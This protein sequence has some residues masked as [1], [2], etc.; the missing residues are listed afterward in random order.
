MVPQIPKR[1]PRGFT[2]VELLAAVAIVAILA[3]I[4][5]PT[6]GAY[7][8]RG[9][10][11]AAQSYLLTLAQAQAQYFADAHTYATTTAAL[12]LPPPG[13]VAAN[14]TIQIDASDGPPPSFTI[15]A[16]PIAG[17]RQ[18]SDSVLTIDNSGARTPSNLW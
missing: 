4:A 9:H 14:Y 18:A 5:Y 16:T 3:A 2:L 11:S 17:T 10:R 8:V 13:D 1:R 12:N 6:Y 15:T 7:L